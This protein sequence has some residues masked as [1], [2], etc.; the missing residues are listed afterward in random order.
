MGTR[1]ASLG[2][3]IRNPQSPIIPATSCKCKLRLPASP[4][5]LAPAPSL[6]VGKGGQFP[7]FYLRKRGLLQ[8]CSSCFSKVVTTLRTDTV[9][10]IYSI[11]VLTRL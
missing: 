7:N 11:R 8:L 9:L 1:G 3:I 10:F 4:S 6:V 5:A 2:N